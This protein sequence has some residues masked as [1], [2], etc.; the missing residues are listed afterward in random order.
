MEVFTTTANAKNGQQHQQPYRHRVQ[1]VL[2][3]SPCFRWCGGRKQLLAKV[4]GV[5]QRFCSVVTLIGTS[6]PFEFPLRGCE[7]PLDRN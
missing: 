5:F 3:G 1:Q 2:E 6:I 4:P 7:L